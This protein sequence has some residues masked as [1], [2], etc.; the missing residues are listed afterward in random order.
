MADTRARELL[1]MGDTLLDRKS[2]LNSLW[3]E[4]ALNTYPERA[5]FTSNRT[6]GEEFASHLF[7][8]YPVLARRELGNSYAIMLRP[9]SVPWFSAHVEDEELDDEHAER[10]Y[11]EYVTKVQ[12]RAM[13]DPIACFVRATKEADHDVAAFGNAII[14]ARIAPNRQHLVHKA[15]HLRDCAW[16]ENATGKIDVLHRNWSPTARQ[17]LEMFPSTVS[18]EVRKAYDKD[19][20]K[21]FACR[22]ISVPTRLYRMDQKIGTLR[23]R[24]MPGTCLYI[25]KDSETVLEET[26]E[27]WF[28]Y[29]VPRWQT[30]T[31]SQYARSP[32]TEIALPDA[33]TF[34]A[35]VRTLREAG[36]MHVNPPMIAVSDALR[37][38]IQLYA[39]GVTTVDIDYD[40]KTGEALRPVDRQPGN[41]PIGFEIAQQVREDLRL[42]FY[43]DKIRLPE[44][45]P[46]KFTAFEFQQRIAAMAREGAPIFDPIEDEYNSPLCDLDFQILNAN[47]AFGAPDTV[48][49]RLRGQSVQFKF[50]SPFRDAQDQAKAGLFMDGL[51]RVLMPAAQI[52][53]S[54]MENANLTEGVRDSLK[55]LGW[56]EE[57]LNDKSKVAGAKAAAA[58]Q[59]EL[60]RGVQGIGAMG[61]AGKS[62]GE[63]MQAMQAPRAA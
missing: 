17:L 33:R 25:E 4:I 12:R 40:E 13:Y 62:V 52:D 31:G 63:A 23:K 36:E 30:V 1:K 48:P 11:L 44:I 14:E 16:S 19:P 37:S 39:G 35:I 56:P 9:P 26:P 43:L 54:Q 8:S 41:M 53:P 59:A 32:A 3:Q 38:D 45:D 21:T 46:G 61:E 57:W 34:Q 7:T 5:D 27:G 10:A 42:G 2:V 49:Q 20:D 60:A 24:E 28:P 50:R 15:H 6:G 18:K 47:G 55:G 29:V 22:V 58:K 51:Q